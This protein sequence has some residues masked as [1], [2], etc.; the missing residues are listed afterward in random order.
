VVYTSVTSL[1]RET[2][3]RPWWYDYCDECGSSPLTEC[4]TVGNL[5]AVTVTGVDESRSHR[6]MF[7]KCHR[8][9]RQV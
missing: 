9:H 4:T 1:S 6:L 3:V 2:M 7:T 8:H 5:T